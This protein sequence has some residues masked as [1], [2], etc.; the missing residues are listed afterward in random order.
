MALGKSLN[1]ILDSYFGTEQVVEDQ[2]TTGQTI[3]NQK[4]QQ[5]TSIKSIP[6][7]L[8][9]LNPHQTRTR[10]DQEKL[11]SLAKDIEINGLLHPISVL[12]QIDPKNNQTTY[13]LLAGERRFRAVKLLN[14]PEI[15]ATVFR[16]ETLTEPQQILLMAMEN[17]Q[18]ENL[19]PLDTAQTYLL[20]MKTQKINYEELGKWLGVSGQHIRNH[21]RLLELAPE[22]QT[23]LQEK[24]LTAGQARAFFVLSHDEQLEILP[25]VLKKNM[26]LESIQKMIMAKNNQK[27]AKMVEEKLKKDK[28]AL[29][30]TENLYTKF[31]S[32]TK[33]L[34]N[35][36]TKIEG[37]EY[38]GSI[39]IRWQK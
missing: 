24:H 22:V 23:A 26:G 27:L 7:N 14:H 33:K 32:F 9:T 12:E 18:R 17:L 8:I 13:L 25:Q 3:I 20:L 29:T 21:T 11:R 31:Q 1:N 4:S 16:Q 39:I 15:L 34:P 6:I 38:G 19:S 30:F 5:K 35:V 2:N 10:I 28:Q 36:E 37:D